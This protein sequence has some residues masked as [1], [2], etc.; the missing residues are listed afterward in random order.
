MDITPPYVHINLEELSKAGILSIK[1]EESPGLQGAT[2]DGVQGA[3]VGTPNAAAVADITAGLDGQEHI[4]K[5]IILTIGLL[6]II[7]AAGKLDVLTIELGIITNEDGA[8]PKLH[9][10]IALEHTTFPI[11]NA[12]FT[13]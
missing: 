9:W 1:T 2:Q 13:Y 12:L 5:G 3:G 10:Q 4:P 11:I 7:V 6:S 8:T